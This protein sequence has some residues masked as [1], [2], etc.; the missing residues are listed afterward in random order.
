MMLLWIYMTCFL[1]CSVST[2]SLTETSILRSRNSKTSKLEFKR[3]WHHYIRAFLRFHTSKYLPVDLQS[4]LS[5]QV[6]FAQAFKMKST[7]IVDEAKK[8]W[9]SVIRKASGQIV[10]Q[11]DSQQMACQLRTISNNPVQQDHYMVK[12]SNVHSCEF[13]WTFN[14]DDATALNLTL[15]NI[16][17]HTIGADCSRGRCSILSLPSLS[18]ASQSGSFQRFTYCGQ[19]APCTSQEMKS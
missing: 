14:I 2:E 16:F 7:Q 3:T 5:R 10:S 15:K 8:T 1:V 17:F 13:L 9:T 18:G 19:H 4:K 12:S 11:Q 6:Y